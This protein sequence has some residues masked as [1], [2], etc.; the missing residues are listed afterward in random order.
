MKKA[1]QTQGLMFLS[2]YFNIVKIYLFF[3]DL[4]FI[5]HP[6]NTAIEKVITGI[7]LSLTTKVLICSFYNVFSKKRAVIFFNCPPKIMRF[8]TYSTAF[9]FTVNFCLQV[10]CTLII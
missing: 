2:L 5:R 6:T 4:N 1:S 3:R 7:F 9:L 10:I 8:L